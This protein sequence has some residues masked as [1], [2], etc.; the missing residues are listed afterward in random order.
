MYI[1][2]VKVRAFLR[3][4]S[5]LR[6]R[7]VAPAAPALFGTGYRGGFQCA[8]R[9]SASPPTKPILLGGRPFHSL[10]M[11]RG[12]LVSGPRH[13][14]ASWMDDDPGLHAIRLER[15]G[16]RRPV[17]EASTLLPG[18]VPHHLRRVSVCLRREVQQADLAVASPAVAGSGNL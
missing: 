7:V 11:W 2:Y 10:E 1:K 3:R 5:A 9:A 17:R 18:S 15:D 8:G 13:A 14:N 12:R 16:N 6:R 4:V